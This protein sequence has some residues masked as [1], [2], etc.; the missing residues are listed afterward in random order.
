MTQPAVLKRWRKPVGHLDL[1][2]PLH[3]VTKEVTKAQLITGGRLITL[4]GLRRHF[5]CDH[6][7]GGLTRREGN[8]WGRGDLCGVQYCRHD[9]IIKEATWWV[10]NR[11]CPTRCLLSTVLFHSV[12]WSTAKRWVLSKKVS[13]PIGLT[14]VPYGNT[15]CYSQFVEMRKSI[16]M[17]SWKWKENFF[18]IF[19]FSTFP[20]LINLHCVANK[21]CKTALKKSCNWHCSRAVSFCTFMFP[22]V[23]YSTLV[24]S[25]LVTYFMSWTKNCNRCY[26]ILQAVWG[27]ERDG[28]GNNQWKWE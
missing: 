14:R 3:H 9:A 18:Y 6:R 2:G 5:S 7:P 23:F 24:Y 21:T 1:P 17:V 12:C 28:D 13:I 8:V 15:N 22:V 16:G 27:C 19:P 26:E 10:H 25:L 20:Q 11:S 4:S